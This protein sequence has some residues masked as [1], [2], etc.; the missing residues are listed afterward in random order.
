MKKFIK[1]IGIILAPVLLLIF[2]LPV[3]RRDRYAGMKDD[4]FNHGIWM[5]DRLH[6]NKKAV[7]I[8]FLGSSH[9]INGINDELIE[10]SL[11]K[12]NLNVANLGYCRLG[13]NLTYTLVKEIITTKKPKVIIIEVLEDEDRYSHPVFP[14]I[15][16]F[17]DLAFPT[18]LFN[19]DI[20]S[21]W[22][23]AFLYKLQLNQ[24]NLFGQQQPKINTDNP[25]GFASSTTFADTKSLENARKSNLLKNN[26]LSNSARNFYMCYPRS[27]L[28]KIQTLC[29]QENIA[30]YFLYLPA[31][32]NC[33]K[34]PAEA[35]TYQKIGKLILPPCR[36]LNNKTYWADELHLNKIGGSELSK[37]IAYEIRNELFNADINLKKTK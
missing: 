25:F 3:H 13:R 15:G 14:N 10:D 16:Y 26:T 31:F 20:V 6:E 22:K 29:Q 28:N 30:L 7:D 23:E 1:N 19:R 37:W 33:E 11:K 8:A 2:L 4:C 27:Y 17:S 18:L 21:D 5:Y 24:N 9:T 34:T 12:Y 36:I 35:A 32:G